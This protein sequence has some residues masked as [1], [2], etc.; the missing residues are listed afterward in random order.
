MG[1]FDQI[2]GEVL[3]KVSGSG[4]G[5]QGGLLQAAMGLI[6]NQEG[7]LAGLVAKFQQ[8]GLG[9]QVASWIGTGANLPV[10]GEQIQAVLGGDVVG[11]LAEKAGISSDALS[12]GLAG[13]LPGLVDKLTPNGEVGD[14]S[15]VQTGL[16]A[17][18]KL[19]G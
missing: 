8:G 17:L 6:N 12:G 11:Q 5:E 2:A 14:S 3:S 19:F 18:G 15:L 4:E 7:G 9:E 1:L 10:S 13:V 16:G